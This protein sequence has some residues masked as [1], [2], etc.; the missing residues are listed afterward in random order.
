MFDH[1][2]NSKYKLNDETQFKRSITII[3]F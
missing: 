2:S 3:I 1:S